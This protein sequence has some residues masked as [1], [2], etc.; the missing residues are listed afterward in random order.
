M[1]ETG[2]TICA[3]IAAAVLYLFAGVAYAQVEVLWLGHG[4]FLVHSDGLRSVEDT[5]RHQIVDMS[6]TFWVDRAI[7]GNME[8]GR[9]SNAH[10]T[11]GRRMP[12]PPKS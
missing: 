7:S 11:R 9:G 4:T 3:A 12:C 5:E 8:P 2:K 1:A 10:P 6:Q